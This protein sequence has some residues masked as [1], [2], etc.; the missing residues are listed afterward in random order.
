MFQVVAPGM[1]KNY[2]NYP[3]QIQASAVGIPDFHQINDTLL[4]LTMETNLN[5][6]VILND[7]SPKSQFTLGC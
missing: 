5:F 4:K 2:P 6:Q 3:I 7:N 1:W